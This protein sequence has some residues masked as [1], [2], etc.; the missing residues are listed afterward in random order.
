[1]NIRTTHLEED[2]DDSIS[3]EDHIYYAH[4]RFF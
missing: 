2:R 3:Q 4:V 1:M